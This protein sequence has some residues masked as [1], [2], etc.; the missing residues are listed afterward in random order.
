MSETIRAVERAIEVLTAFSPECVELTLGE[1][2]AIVDLPKGSTHRVV[3]TLKQYDFIYQDGETGKYRLGAAA[4][5][6]GTVAKESFSIEKIVAPYMKKLTKATMQTTN[7]Y[8][9]R[10][11]ERVCIAQE[12]GLQ[13]VRRYSYLGAKH[14]LYCGAGKIFLAYASP[15]FFERYIREVKLERY[16][17]RT[18]TEP[19]ELYENVKDI[20]EK[21]YCCTL[22]ER[23]EVSAQIAAPIFGH[24]QKLVA[25][26]T[27]SGPVY[28]F[29]E[30][31]IQAY[32][33]QIMSVCREISHE[34]GFNESKKI[35]YLD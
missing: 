12:E 2:S 13:Y 7:L 19:A 18:I 3:S 33:R 35:E 17:A 27:V 16:T 32:A 11:F 24:T 23:D 34:I 5:R 20:C 22:G 25:A 10:G 21:G 28:V 26:L 4:I 9:L 14:P 31:Q 1:I 8:V 15:A 30:D 6:L 29:T